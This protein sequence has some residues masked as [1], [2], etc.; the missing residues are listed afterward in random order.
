MGFYI[1]LF[2]WVHGVYKA[3]C[4]DELLVVEFQEIV[5]SL[6]ISFIRCEVQ[7]R[8]HTYDRNSVLHSPLSISVD[9]T[10]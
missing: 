1:Y 3:S 4:S 7:H 8:Q 9:L 5:S 10:W 6:L 2:V